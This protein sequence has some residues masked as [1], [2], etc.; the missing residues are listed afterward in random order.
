[1]ASLCPAKGIGVDQ[2]I[3][4]G[5]FLPLG[6]VCALGGDGSTLVTFALLA[7]RGIWAPPL[8]DRLKPISS[9]LM[10]MSFGVAV[11]ISPSLCNASC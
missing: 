10:S 5:L 8:A 2:L 9:S 7:R 6:P 11:V 4:S 1:M 3:Y